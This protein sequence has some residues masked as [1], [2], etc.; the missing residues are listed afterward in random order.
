MC[1]KS[2]KTC[3]WFDADYAP[4]EEEDYAYGLCEWPASRLPYSFRWE[5]GERTAVHPIDG[6]DCS[7]WEPK[8]V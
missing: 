6:A 3:R 8:G 2:C 1:E 5:N 7:C 4:D